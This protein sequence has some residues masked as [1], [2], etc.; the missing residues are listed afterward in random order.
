MS[1]IVD[2]LWHGETAPVQ[3]L[4]KG[5]LFGGGKSRKINPRCAVAMLVIIALFAQLSKRRP[6][7]SMQFQCEHSA[8]LRLD[9]ID[10]R[11]LADSDLR[12]EL[13]DRAALDERLERE[14]VVAGEGEAIAVRHS[15][16]LIAQQAMFDELAHNLG[17][18]A[19]LEVGDG[20]DEFDWHDLVILHSHLD[21]GE[22][23]EALHGEIAEDVHAQLS[24][25]L[26]AEAILAQLIL[27]TK[28]GRY[29]N[30]Y[31]RRTESQGFNPF[32][33]KASRQKTS[34]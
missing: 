1:T 2:R 34:G 6:A 9:L 29:C 30:F 31:D 32:T 13:D 26:I 25:R 10:V 19:M 3:C 21:C 5:K 8:V 20:D 17:A 15:R 11:F 24:H 27:S 22:N 33:V 14:V 12:S 23:A 7:K 4:H 28:N 18:S 16:M